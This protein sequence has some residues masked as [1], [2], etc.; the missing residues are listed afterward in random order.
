MARVSRALGRSLALFV[1]GDP[2]WGEYTVEARVKFLALK[3]MAGLVHT[4]SRPVMAGN[5]SPDPNAEPRVYVSGSDEGFLI[6]DIRGKLLKQV[7][8]GHN[9]SPSVGK[10]RMDVPG[11]QYMTVNFWRNPRVVTLFDWTAISWRRGSR[12]TPAL[13]CCR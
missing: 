7:R 10:F 9:Q 12:S 2:E 13:R 6:F 4:N 8:V 5:L 3:D 1:T 11:L